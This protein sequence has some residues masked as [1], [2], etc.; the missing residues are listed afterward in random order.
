MAKKKQV[1]KREFALID[2]SNR[3]SEIS[4][5]SSDEKIAPVPQYVFE[6]LKH[7]LRPY[8]KQAL[9]N[10]NWTQRDADNNKYNHLMFNM[11]TGSG[12]TDLMA[13]IVLYMYGEY[14][15][16]NFL[17]VSNTNAVV[18]KAKENFL[19]ETGGKYLF[20][21]PI[22]I[23]GKRISIKDVNHFS[24]QMSNDTI[25]MKLT[26]VQSLSN[27]LLSI[28]E[29]GLT[30]D[31]LENQKIVILADE[32]HHF[33]AS[34]KKDKLTQHTW[35]ALLDKIRQANSANRQFEFT[36]TI[37]VDK[38]EVYQK[39]R[40]KIIYKYELDKFMGEGYSKSVYRLQ[41]NNSDKEK[42]LNAVLL[43]QYRK[44]LAKKHNI[45]DFKPVILF[46]SNLVKVS[47]QAQAEFLQLIKGLTASDLTQFIA[48]QLK[49]THSEALRHTY[50]YW[51]NVDMTE[52]VS[53]IKRDFERKTSVNVND[54][55]SEGILGDKADFK[56]LN[57]L[58]DPNNPIRTIFAVAKLTE[59]WD[60]LNLFDIVRIG[61]QSTTLMQTNSEAQLIGRGARYYPFE[62]EGERSYTRRFNS[63]ENDMYL[64]E[65]L[66]YHTINDSKYINNLHK[67]FDKMNLVSENDDDSNYQILS[68]KVKE[69]F[70][71]TK[72][73]KRGK[74]YQ[75]KQEDVPAEDY[76]NIG[77]YGVDGKTMMVNVNSSTMEAGVSAAY[78]NETA[79]VQKTV[80]DFYK[81]SDRRLIKK[82]MARDR[83]YRYDVLSTYVPKLKSIEEFITSNDWL[84]R[85]K[86]V[87]LVSDDSIELSMEERCQIVQK[88]LTKIKEKI[89]QNYQKKRGT[90]EFY[91]VPISSIVHD[92][93]KRVYTGE[94]SQVSESIFSVDM[95]KKS[96]F[97]YDRAIVDHLEHEFISMIGRFVDDNELTKKY[98]D[99]YLIRNEETIDG[100]KIFEFQPGEDG[101]RHYQG[102]MPDFILYLAD[103]DQQLAYQIFAEP[104]GDQLLNKDGWKQTL[105]ESLD[106]IEVIAENEK[107]KLL[108]LKF[109]LRGDQ[110]HIE[111]E[112]SNKL[113]IDYRGF[114]FSM[115]KQK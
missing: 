35:E 42:M 7:Q 28:R 78:D 39:Y 73:Y 29:N 106:N 68:A 62:Y 52:A 87:A 113:G 101:V 69:G 93:S 109:Y 71:R 6:N 90:K 23:D 94:R 66:Y 17:F 91:P 57:T 44:R 37:D 53:E 48:D 50:E 49:I 112:L 36:A 60:V 26:T 8:Q 70:Q 79:D 114:K 19:N 54:T 43:S 1:V 102:F 56:K 32:A 115:D 88:A 45:A 40:D 14:G 38:E 86:V 22:N 18:E 5:F 21:Q 97:V 85:L 16:R 89:K 41:A 31:D 24:N 9:F 107:I 103:R 55:A 67:S 96:W 59:G 34:T 74:L 15:Y 82:A 13:A 12:K 2:E 105:L 72:V 83:F 110:N 108:G 84:G 27:E 4:L 46:K 20:S 30:F 10:L 58:E 51:K 3:K 11:A 75:N 76:S 111:E 64:L 47:K 100:L 98:D 99:V 25:Q 61:E 33:N 81:A 80:C 95:S 65:S 92:Y 104:K 77:A 63:K